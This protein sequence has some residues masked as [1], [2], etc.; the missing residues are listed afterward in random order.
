M[1]QNGII[2][3]YRELREELKEKGYTFCSDTDTEVIPHLI[4]EY[5][6]H[7]GSDTVL[8]GAVCAA[9]SDSAGGESGCKGAFALAIVSVDFPDE[10]IVV[11]Q[12]APLAIGFGQGEFFCA[13][14]TPAIMPYTQAVLTLEN[15]EI[16]KA[17]A[18]GRRGV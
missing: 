16:G 9:R 5:L 4:D 18:A 1:V 12:Q 8:S 14:D 10:L 11:R 13:S 17:D 6:K 2:E 7:P 3:N 15:G